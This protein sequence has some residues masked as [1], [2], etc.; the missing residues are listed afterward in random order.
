[1]KR[2][3]LDRAQSRPWVGIGESQMTGRMRGIQHGEIPLDFVETFIHLGRQ[4]RIHG[5]QR[6][7]LSK[8]ASVVHHLNGLRPVFVSRRLAREFPARE[9]GTAIGEDGAEQLRDDFLS[10]FP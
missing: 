7:R 3:F 2:Q 6:K 10:L 1:M 5:L 8:L 4:R 9:Y